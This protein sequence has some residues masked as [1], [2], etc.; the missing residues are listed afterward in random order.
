MKIVL[1]KIL[2]GAIGGFTSVSALLCILGLVY[3]AKESTRKKIFKDMV[4]FILVA[5]VAWAVVIGI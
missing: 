3:E 4:K 2:A 1:I 5:I